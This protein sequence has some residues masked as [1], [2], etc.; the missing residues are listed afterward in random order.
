MRTLDAE[1]FQATGKIVSREV[2]LEDAPMGRLAGG[3]GGMQ[4]SRRIEPYV[5][6]LSETCP[7]AAPAD[8]LLDLIDRDT[9]LNMGAGRH[10]QR[11][12]GGRDIVQM[13][14]QRHH[15]REQIKWRGDMLHAAFGR[16]GTEAIDSDAPLNADGT[17][18]MPGQ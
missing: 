16:P 11:S 13:D 7:Y 2:D 10:Q 8:N 14:A 12:V 15:A 17:I 1:P 18:L 9:P 5:P 4:D 3:L 6:G